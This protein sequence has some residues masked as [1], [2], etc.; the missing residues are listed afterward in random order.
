MKN[1][2]SPA[3]KLDYIAPYD[4]FSG[5]GMLVG[6][7]FGFAVRDAKLGERV[8]LGI[9]GTWGCKKTAGQAWTEG[10]VLYW[11]NTAKLMTSTVGT[12]K[13]VGTARR[14]ALAAD[15]VGEIVLNASRA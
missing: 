11:D 14:A 5:D 9:T 10:Q 6:A 15:V 3:D 4:V 12:N 2:I 8:T 7:M 1:Y 13:L